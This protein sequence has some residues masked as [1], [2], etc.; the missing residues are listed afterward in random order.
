MVLQGFRGNLAG[1]RLTDSIGDLLIEASPGKD[2][3]IK[4][5]D[6]AG[7]HKILI[8]NSNGTTV[9]YITST[10]E[11]SFLSVTTDIV[12]ANIGYTAGIHAGS[13]AHTKTTVNAALDSLFM[14]EI[15]AMCEQSQTVPDGTVLTFETVGKKIYFSSKLMAFKNGILQ[16]RGADYVE[17]LTRYSVTF[18]N[19]PETDDLVEFSYIRA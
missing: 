18:T 10:G 2:V 14:A 16:R 8:K 6:A 3:V 5:S 17:D 13:I 1:Y 9:G 4:L 19:A 7:T 15:W 12:Y 11:A